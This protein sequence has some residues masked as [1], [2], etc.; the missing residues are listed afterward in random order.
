[1]PPRL[2]AAEAVVELV[3]VAG[4]SGLDPQEGVSVHAEG[5]HRANGSCK[6]LSA[7]DIEILEL[8]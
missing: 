8:F 6:L 4:Q 3:Q 7:R 1:M 2:A 5:L